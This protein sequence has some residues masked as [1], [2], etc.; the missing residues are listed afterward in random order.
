MSL[1]ERFW[2]RV[3][4]GDGCWLWTGAA[5]LKGYGM[6]TVTAAEAHEAPGCGAKAKA[7][8]VAWSLVNGAVPDGMLVCHRCDVP[9]CVNP[10][11]LFLGTIRDN[12]QDAAAKG[13][14]ARKLTDEEVAQIRL[15]A[16]RGIAGHQIGKMY[17]VATS[18][19][20]RIAA[21]SVRVL[22]TVDIGDGGL[23][24]SASPNTAQA[25]GRG[26]PRVPRLI[27]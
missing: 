21:R 12:I 25:E 18:T 20:N 1:R 2:K 4:K 26:S 22:R 27:L 23:P 15:L 5:D 10:A 14:M 24:P 7:H 11:H 17:G 16:A 8:R 3:E 6:I 9:A 19:V 13:R